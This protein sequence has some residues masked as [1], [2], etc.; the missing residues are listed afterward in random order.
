MAGLEKYRE[1]R[2]FEKTP[3]PGVEKESVHENRFVVQKHNATRT[4]YDLRLQVGNVL[5]SWAIP[6]EPS[7]DPEVKRLAIRTENHPVEYLSF[8]GVIPVG[9]YGAGTMMVWDQGTYRPN[10]TDAG[11]A[12]AISRKIEKGSVKIF[13]EGQKLRGN[14]SLYRTGEKDGKEQWIFS[15]S[16]DEHASD[17]L[18]F[19]ERSVIS[20]RTMQEI[21]EGGDA[22][23]A[24]DPHDLDGARK[25]AFADIKPMLATLGDAA[26]DHPSWIFE[27]KLDGYRIL[28]AKSGKKQNLI[29]RN[30]NIYNDNYPPVF[31][32]LKDIPHDYIIDGEVVVLDENGRSDFGELQNLDKES[33]KRLFYYVFDLLWLD[34]YDLTDM[35]LIRRKEALKSILPQTLQRIRYLDHFPERGKDFFEQTI[36]MNLEGMIAKRKASRYVP[37]RRSEE[38]IKVKAVKQQEV[39][40]A[41]YTPPKGSRQHFGSLVLAVNENG[42]LRYAG[43]VGTGFSDKLLASIH[44]KLIPL[45]TDEPPVS[46]KLPRNVQWVKPELMA[47]VRFTEW[48]SGGIMRHPAFKGLRSDKKVREV[49]REKPDISSEKINVRIKLS[50]PGKIFWPEKK[51]TKKDVYDYYAEIAPV[52]LPYLRNRPQSLFRTPDGV[53]GSGFFQK[54]VEGLAP[55]WMETAE[56]ESSS[57]GKTKTWMLCQDKPSLLFMV[58]LGCVEIN[59]WNASMPDLNHPDYVVFDLD[60]LDIEFDKV[61]DVAAG[62]RD[63]FQDLGLPFFCKTSGGRGIHIYLPVEKRYSHDQAQ[64]LARLIETIIHGRFKKITSFERSPSRRKGKI[65]LDYLQNG[66]G[67]TMASVYSLRPKKGAG[68]STPLTGEELKHG[69]DPLGF[70]IFTIHNRLKEKGDLWEGI[71][72]RRVNLSVV[73]DKLDSLK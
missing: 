71:F 45:H 3:E 65:Y 43:R 44:K 50:N 52:I 12:A 55:E 27:I 29:S 63:L 72:E 23:K 67:K 17:D 14:F 48:T 1:K 31:Q 69:L 24:I 70:N 39:V 60:P 57:S 22:A 51:I 9:N 28:A 35:P 56:L 25:A 61:V 32:E 59:P 46:G 64:Q 20:G 15:K 47:E 19:E 53:K 4:H 68:I 26:F 6:K 16:K 11:D 49:K 54:D 33:M 58:N 13:F 73:L 21:A 42:A 7:A 38:W 36:R 5:L 34:G 37:G 66:R 18:S 2:N 62:F 8:E 41:G 40:I 30:G 10:D